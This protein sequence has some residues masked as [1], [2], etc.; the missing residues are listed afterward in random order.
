MG[1]ARWKSRTEI[2][3]SGATVSAPLTTLASKLKKRQ[4]PKRQAGSI[5]STKELAIP[6]AGAK[7]RADDLAEDRFLALTTRS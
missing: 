6:S 5:L 3:V 7:D 2:E 1:R 4:S